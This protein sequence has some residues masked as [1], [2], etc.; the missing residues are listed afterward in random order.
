M[1]EGMECCL[2]EPLHIS[3]PRDACGSAAGVTRE[4]MYTNEQ[5]GARREAE[6]QMLLFML[7]L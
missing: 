5:A 6:R 3:R 1:S 2:K 7:L 4:T